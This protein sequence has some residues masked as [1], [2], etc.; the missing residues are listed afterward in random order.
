MFQEDYNSKVCRV[1]IPNPTVPNT[2]NSITDLNAKDTDM[3]KHNTQ[4]F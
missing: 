3:L 4:H 2:W 1:Q